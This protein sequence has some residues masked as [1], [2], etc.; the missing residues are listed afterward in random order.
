MKFSCTFALLIVLLLGCKKDKKPYNYLNGPVA[1]VE[2]KG[3]AVGWGLE[4]WRYSNDDDNPGAY[5]NL[6]RPQFVKISGGYSMT[7][8]IK[9][10]TITDDQRKKSI[11]SPFPNSVSDTRINIYTN[12]S[13]DIGEYV[14]YFS[15][16]KKDQ[17]T[18]VIKLSVG[19]Y[20]AGR[21]FAGQSDGDYTKIKII[22][23]YAVRITVDP[24]QVVPVEE[25]RTFYDGEFEFQVTSDGSGGDPC[26][27]I[28][29]KF[30][31]VMLVQ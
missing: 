24:F 25:D 6:G 3:F 26:K 7:Q 1:H 23:K 14:S 19:G 17:I 4:E 8:Y 16:A 11:I 30:S 2:F 22:R 21:N 9:S 12:K 15:A 20:T 29:G 18:A 5:G 27:I 10:G 13:L 28:E 31:G